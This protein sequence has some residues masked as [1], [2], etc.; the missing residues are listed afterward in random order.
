MGLHVS[1]FK[2]LTEKQNLSKL[3]SLWKKKNEMEASCEN[4]FTQNMPLSIYFASEDHSFR[5]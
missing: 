4:I 3:F 1:N 2:D 5:D